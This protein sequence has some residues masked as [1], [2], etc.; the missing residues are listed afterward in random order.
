MG[1]ILILRVGR[2]SGRSGKDYEVS[3][4]GWDGSFELLLHMLPIPFLLSLPKNRNYPSQASHFGVK[5]S[6]VDEEQGTVREVSGRLRVAIIR[7]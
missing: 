2:V 6:Q 7:S 5:L 4:D 3:W 1:F